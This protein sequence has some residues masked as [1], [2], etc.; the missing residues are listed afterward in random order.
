MKKPR[1][2]KKGNCEICCKKAEVQRPIN[3]FNAWCCLPCLETMEARSAARG[4]KDNLFG[5]IFKEET[6]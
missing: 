5:N 6:K 1:E 3:S 2:F 4:R